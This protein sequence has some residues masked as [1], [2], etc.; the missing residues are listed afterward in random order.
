[1]ATIVLSA[2]GAA[3]GGS[4]GGSIVGLSTAVIG[5]AVGATLGNAIDQRLLGGGAA[6]DTGRIERFRLNAA[7]EGAA[8]PLVF[9]RM[10]VGGQVI[11]ASRFEER[12]ETTGG[13]KGAPSQP[14]V[15]R[16]SY[17]VSLAIS[18]GEGEI[19]RVGRV[20]ADGTEIA[21]DE[22]VMRV[23]PGSEDQLPDPKIEAVE[24]LGQAPAYRG[25]A[26]VVI[27][28]LDLTTFGNR[29]PQFNFEVVRPEPE[30][31]AG[32]PDVSRLVRGMA[33]MPGTGEYALATSPVH[34]P[35]APGANRSA[36]V[37][38]PGGETD[39]VVSLRALREEVP[40]CRSVSLIVSWFGDDL[41]CGACRVQPKV[42]QVEIDGAGMPWRAGG[43]GRS[44]AQVIAQVDG[45]PV[46]GGTP[47]DASVVEAIRRMR[48]EGI[49]VLFY[50]FLLMEQGPGNGRPDPWS[51][52]GDQPVYPWRGRITLSE[53]PGRPG[54]PDGT[55]TAEAEV[56][57]FFGRPSRR[58]S[59]WW[60]IGSSTLVRRA[61]AIG[62]SSCTTRIS[63]PWRAGSSPSAWAPRCAR[64]RR[65]GAWQ[66]LSG[67][68][69]VPPACG[70][71]PCDPRPRCEDQLRGRLVGVLRL[72]AAGRVGRRLLPPR[73][74]LGRPERR[75]HRDRQLHAAVGLARGGCAGGR[76]L[77]QPLQ[78][79]LS[80][81]QHRGRRGLRLV[82]RDADC[83]GGAGAHADHGRRIRRALG[84]PLQGPAVLVVRAA[85]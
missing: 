66:Q 16:F 74:A 42:E 17:S 70:R 71:G 72:P 48:D 73:S 84:L 5:R 1:M 43:I 10:R 23:Y 65:S 77:G 32:V 61:S 85:S 44:E 78:P 53:A 31:Q 3:L 64:S 21:P 33:M 59:R 39:F 29:V 41:R 38:T 81:G 83:G 26:Y 68:G 6:V 9:G 22:I 28:D 4:L 54:S 62:G 30:G 40:E 8:L 46:Y 25:T 19:A 55:A 36:N 76:C 34:Y 2:A 50:P 67:G 79:R 56:A 12:S 52:A 63:A 15:T 80:E 58:I 47:S 14:K 37:H 57:A 7:S 49:D 45:R 75:F 20:W 11:W 82:L 51:D 18:L 60:A 27:E 24:G 13:G 35:V 69:G